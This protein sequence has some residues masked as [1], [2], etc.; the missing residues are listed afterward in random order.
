[1]ELAYMRLED[2]LQSQITEGPEH[3]LV[4]LQ[5]PETL[6]ECESSRDNSLNP[7][8]GPRNPMIASILT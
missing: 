1:M 6:T 5:R 2:E 4:A 8:V 3:A 7:L